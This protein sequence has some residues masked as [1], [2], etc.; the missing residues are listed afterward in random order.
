MIELPRVIL[1]DFD[2]T[3]VDSMN[4]WTD[5]DIEYLAR[6]GQPYSDDLHSAIEGMSTKEMCN[7]FHSRYDI[8]QTDE[9]MIRTWTEMSRHKYLYEI[10]LK[11]GVKE[12]LPYLKREGIRMGIATSTELDILIPCLKSHG[13]DGY[14]ETLTTTTEAG[15]GKPSPAVYLLAAERM[16]ADPSE[17]M[18][19]EDLPAGII[20]AKE[21][22]M[23]VLAVDDSFSAG[24]RE[25]KTRL[26]DRFIMSL[27]EL[28]PEHGLSGR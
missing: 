19:I 18:A 24:R 13:I 21:A 12:L 26:A 16:G 7:Y 6:F 3:L 9:E 11:D 8:P 23:T 4:M 17:C 25:E 27:S 10:P 22:G 14:F 15:A 2:G 28:L 5:I 1:F 20:A